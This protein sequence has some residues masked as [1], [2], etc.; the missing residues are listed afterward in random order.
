MTQGEALGA[1]AGG[2]RPPARNA[3]TPWGP[4]DTE[5]ALLWSPQR[6]HS[7]AHTSALAFWP[8]SCENTC[9]CRQPRRSWGLVPAVPGGQCSAHRAPALISSTMVPPAHPGPCPLQETHRARH[10]PRGRNAQ[11]CQ[12]EGTRAMGSGHLLCPCP[13]CEGPTDQD[14]PF[15]AAPLLGHPGRSP[16]RR[17]PS[18]QKRGPRDAT[19][20]PCVC[21][22]SEGA[23]PLLPQNPVQ[24]RR[25]QRPGL[26]D[27]RRPRTFDQTLEGH[28]E[29]PRCPCAIFSLEGLV[30]RP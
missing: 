30:V 13:G 29:T 15:A 1:E 26:T 10:V 7:P 8:Q 17:V 22:A 3:W 16:E 27:V 5:K 18:R 11:R 21:L 19:S 24:T 6:G 2:L 23:G 28:Q 25:G 4:E 20:T 12:V 14:G 9:F